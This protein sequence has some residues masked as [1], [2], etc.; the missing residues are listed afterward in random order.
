VRVVETA[1]VYSEGLIRQILN[2]VVDALGQSE[3]LVERSMD[4]LKMPRN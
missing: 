2:D 3:Q 1:Q 4:K